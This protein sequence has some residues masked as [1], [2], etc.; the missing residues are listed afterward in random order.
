[1]GAGEGSMFVGKRKTHPH[2]LRDTFGF[3]AGSQ[4]NTVAVP[5]LSALQMS[6]LLKLCL[7]LLI[8]IPILQS[9]FIRSS[10]TNK[11]LHNYLHIQK[12][13]RVVTSSST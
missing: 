13:F 8:T 2:E 7:I 1:M 11:S 5:P 6:T 12:P 10:D 3:G 4:K 9:F